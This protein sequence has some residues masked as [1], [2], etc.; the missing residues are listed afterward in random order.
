MR[1]WELIP[2]WGENCGIFPWVPL[3]GLHPYLWV[4]AQI[5][6][7]STM[8]ITLSLWNS[9]VVLLRKTCQCGRARLPPSTL[10]SRMGSKPHPLGSEELALDNSKRTGPLPETA[11]E[12]ASVSSDEAGL[13]QERTAWAAMVKEKGQRAVELQWEGSW[14]ETDWQQRWAN[15]RS[16]DICRIPNT[17]RA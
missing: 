9:I 11:T 5:C 2:R 10:L 14:S 3:R 8:T 4:F 6:T 17:N 13:G 16:M 7:G 15:Y 1:S 12:A